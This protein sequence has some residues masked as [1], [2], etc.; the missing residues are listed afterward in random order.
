MT[1]PG[2]ARPTHHG[3][4]LSGKKLSKFA[5]YLMPQR[6]IVPDVSCCWETRLCLVKE[7]LVCELAPSHFTSLVTITPVYHHL[8]KCSNAT[9]I[10]TSDSPSIRVPISSCRRSLP[11]RSSDNTCHGRLHSVHTPL[12]CPSPHLYLLGQN[13]SVAPLL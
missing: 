7:T 9:A 4:R 12:T 5:L 11:E 6:C 1:G 3:C 13:I 2:R 10:T 8:I